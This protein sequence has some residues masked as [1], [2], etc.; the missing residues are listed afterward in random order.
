[1]WGSICYKQSWSWV[2]SEKYSSH[3]KIS[4]SDCRRDNLLRSTCTRGRSCKEPAAGLRAAACGG[5]SVQL[6][7]MLCRRQRRRFVV[8][9]GVVRRSGF[10]D[11]AGGSRNL[12]GGLGGAQVGCNYQTGTGSLASRATMTGLAPVAAPPPALHLPSS[13]PRAPIPGYSSGTVNSL[14]SVTGRV[15][16]AWDRFLGYVK[17][18]GAREKRRPRSGATF[19]GVGAGTIGECQRYSGR[20]D[21]ARELAANTL[22][23]IGLPALLNTTT[24]GSASG[25]STSTASPPATRVRNPTWAFRSRSAGWDRTHRYQAHRRRLEGR[26][27]RQSWRLEILAAGR[28]L[29][30][31]ALGEAW[32]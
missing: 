19:V 13:P 32:T 29:A 27:E 25:L 21:R 11:R 17:G 23:G 1:M 24:T 30:W 26:F 31:G 6:D 8:A 15:G 20:L 5:P 12:N 9:Q 4:V 22:S 28:P 10:F 14:A 16:Y 3:E 7:R 18:G 2:N